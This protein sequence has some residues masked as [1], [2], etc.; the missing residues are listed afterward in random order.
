MAWRITITLSPRPFDQPS[1]YEFAPNILYSSLRRG[2]EIKTPPE[3]CI[4]AMERFATT[5]EY[6]TTINKDKSGHFQLPF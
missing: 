6:S 5:I 3:M 2:D 1:F 4:V